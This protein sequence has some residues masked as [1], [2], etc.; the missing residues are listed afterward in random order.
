MDEY[1]KIAFGVLF[2]SLVGGALGYIFQSRLWGHQNEARLRDEEA[3]RADEVSQALSRLL[4][5][6][7]YRMLRLF[8][9]SRSLI[10]G[11]GQRA[12]AEKCREDYNVVLYEWNDNLNIN[13]ALIGTYFGKSARDWLSE[14]V[15]L[16]YQHV[17]EQVQSFYRSAI[18]GTSTSTDA[19]KE[20]EGNL[21]GLND[22]VYRLN[23]FM[24]TQLRGGEVGRRAP[25]PQVASGSPEAVVEGGVPLAG[26]EAPSLTS[27]PA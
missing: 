8:Y 15:Y 6:R 26:I 5:R 12:E 25:Y 14:R 19:F 13:L 1:L 27:R 9:A 7:L 22:D 23:V 3:R 17:G 18:A 16:A 10:N 2:T 20:L 4:D 21:W 11:Q 24:M